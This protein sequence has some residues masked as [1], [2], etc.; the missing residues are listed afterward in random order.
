MVLMQADA[1]NKWTV[2]WREEVKPAALSATKTFYEHTCMRQSG[3]SV[4]NFESEWTPVLREA[5]PSVPKKSS[6]WH[7][8]CQD[9]ICEVCPNRPATRLTHFAKALPRCTIRFEEATT[10][11]HLI[12]QN[13]KG[14]SMFAWQ[15]KL[16]H[17][18]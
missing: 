14:T 15:E 11:R 12:D 4:L 17:K 13:K 1:V 7:D 18:E 9:V 10:R 2:L 8:S 16:M 5:M 6:A 3:G